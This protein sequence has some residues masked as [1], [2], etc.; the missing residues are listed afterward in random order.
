M[1]KKMVTNQTMFDGQIHPMIKL[2]ID[3]IHTLFK[4]TPP[5]SKWSQHLATPPNGR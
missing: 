4:A 3:P 2:R 5:S 1:W